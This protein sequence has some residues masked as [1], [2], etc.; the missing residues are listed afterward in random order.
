V[1][2]LDEL[3]ILRY[4]NEAIANQ[5]QNKVIKPNRSKML[6]V[7]TC[8]EQ[9]FTKDAALKAAF[10]SFTPGKQREF[11]EHILEAKLE[12]TKL[13]RLNKIIPIIKQ[14]IGLNDKY[15]K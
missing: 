1:E 2:E 8:L 5:K 12:K 14:N 10:Y 7:P 15:R 9:A 6:S 11:S 13:A 4:I 3:L